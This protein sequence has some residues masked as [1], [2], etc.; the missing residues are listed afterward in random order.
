MFIAV[1]RGTA[2]ILQKKKKKYTFWVVKYM[3]LFTS[4]QDVIAG[5]QTAHVKTKPLLTKKK[6]KKNCIDRLKINKGN[7]NQIFQ[8]SSDV[9]RPI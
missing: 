3:A 9:G 1:A 2:D 7:S 4:H 6:K 8:I 5:I